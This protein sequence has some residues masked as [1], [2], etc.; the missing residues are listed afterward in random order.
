MP[1]PPTPGGSG[2]LT[3]EASID[4]YAQPE[5]RIG[6]G[7]QGTVYKYTHRPTGKVYAAKVMYY[8]NGNGDTNYKRNILREQTVALE[9]EHVFICRTCY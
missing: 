7:A 3:R 4:C 5:T 1:F 6:A 8:N 9:F 2:P